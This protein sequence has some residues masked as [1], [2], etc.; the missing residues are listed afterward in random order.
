MLIE[1]VLL[2]PSIKINQLQFREITLVKEKKKE[3]IDLIHVLL[4]LCISKRKTEWLIFT[5]TSMKISHT[6]LQI[7]S[8]NFDFSFKSFLPIGWTIKNVL[9]QVKVEKKR[10]KS[11]TTL[12]IMRCEHMNYFYFYDRRKMFFI[13]TST[14][15]FW[16]SR[17][18]F[19]HE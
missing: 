3:Q 13:K 8:L 2:S 15:C 17:G 18:L 4:L 6:Y 14:S 16:V 5:D 10:E 12:L 7:F 1:L 9:D 19:G 11:P